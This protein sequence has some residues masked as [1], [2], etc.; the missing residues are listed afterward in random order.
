MSM[1]APMPK[2]LKVIRFALLRVLILILFQF[3]ISSY[4]RINQSC[5]QSLLALKRIHATNPLHKNL[6]TNNAGVEIE[7]FLPESFTRE[8]VAKKL[9][10]ILIRQAKDKENVSLSQSWDPTLGTIYD[11]S[12]DGNH[13]FIKT[14]PSIKGDHTNFIPLELNTP[15]IKSEEDLNN[16]LDIVQEL[17]NHFGL[18]IDPSDSGIHVRIDFNN[19]SDSEIG[20]LILSYSVLEETLIKAFSTHP[21]RRATYTKALPNEYVSEV[22][23]SL[24]KKIPFTEVE[25]L[26]QWLTFKHHSL[27]L[28]DLFLQFSSRPKTAE[29]RLFNATLDTELLNIMIKAPQR[30]I[31]KIRS[32]DPK[33][34][35]WLHS[36]NYT[37]ES[38]L[39]ILDFDSESIKMLLNR[40]AEE[41]E[42]P[43]IQDWKD[44]SRKTPA[45]ALPAQ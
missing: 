18:K 41:S 23:K 11:V 25:R 38:L 42:N 8:D 6:E 31:T 14:E 37:P 44:L 33:F 22:I 13:W 2:L 30:L 27:N 20:E 36:G 12:L 19:A 29:F 45:V 21:K 15:V 39:E 26:R 9:S 5:D 1:A 43:F 32:R 40:V 10:Q 3:S 24:S 7:A 28:T 34:Y 17:R 16:I 4:S 35:K